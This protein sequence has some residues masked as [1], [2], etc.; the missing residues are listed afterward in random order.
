MLP[1]LPPKDVEAPLEAHLAELRGRL[2]VVVLVI[3]LLSMGAFTVT[4]R[5]ILIL[6][7]DLHF[8]W[9]NRIGNFD[10]GYSMLCA[11]LSFLGVIFLSLVP[12]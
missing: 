11:K 8:T 2:L 5:L 9:L 7:K 10:Q 12:P 6:K 1:E 4:D 3:L